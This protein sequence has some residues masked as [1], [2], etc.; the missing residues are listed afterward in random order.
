MKNLLFLISL[1]VG[2]N[3]NAQESK[4]NTN[5]TNVETTIKV[6]GV[7]NMCKE[8]IENAALRT[9]GVKFAEWN[10]ET[11]ILEL[12]FNGKKTSEEEIHQAIADH[13]H[14]TELVKADSS[15]YS[16]LPNCCKYNDG[17][18]CAH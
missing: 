18:E 9:K 10:K 16:Q 8:R 7:C 13:G 1:L 12:V 14:E 11:Q 2:L 17:A 5:S 15:V 4:K 6:K 3:L